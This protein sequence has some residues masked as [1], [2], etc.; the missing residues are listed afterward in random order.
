MELIS[1]PVL[2]PAL[3]LIGYFICYLIGAGIE[4]NHYRSIKR[5]ERSYRHLPA[6][7]MADPK[8]DPD[9]I[10]GAEL[11]CGNVV[12][13]IDLFKSMAALIRNIFGGRITTYE[14]LIDRARRE[15]L[16][17]MK[18]TAVGA[19]MITNVRIETARI[20]QRAHKGFGTVEA[21]AYGTALMLRK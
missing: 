14:S 7:T 21:V 8:V 3:I 16:L 1:N 11:V 12:I 5:R 9:A 19:S 17:R 4:K 15:A 13:S 18:E 2:F 6:V 10:V 20:G